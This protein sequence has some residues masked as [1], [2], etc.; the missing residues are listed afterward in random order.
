MRDVLRVETHRPNCG[1]RKGIVGG[2]DSVGQKELGLPL[3]RVNLDW[4]NHGRADQ[5]AAGMTT[6][7]RLPTR[8]GSP[9]GGRSAITPVFFTVFARRR[10]V[11]TFLVEG[12][13][14]PRAPIKKS[15]PNL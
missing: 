8:L 3:R 6:V 9:A 12:M 4:K 1:H 2:V 11:W 10:V 15:C 7:P 13:S 14:D 5:N